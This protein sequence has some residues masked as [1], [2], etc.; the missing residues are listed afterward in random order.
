MHEINHQLDWEQPIVRVYGRKYPV[1]RMSCFL[2]DK[3]I[4]YKYSGYEHRG[5]GWPNWF[6][7]LLDKVNK[8]CEAEFN[9]CLLNLYR[10]GNDSMGWH[11]DNE[12]ELD[13]KQPIA[14]LSFGTTR[15]FYL[16]HKIFKYREDLI[17]GNGDLLIMSP[18]CQNSW[19]HSVP[20]RRK[21]TGS[22]IN[23]TFR[24]YKLKSVF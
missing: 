13:S 4:T 5:Y 24:Y 3:Y 8:K 10:N 19:L 14:S 2:A 1:P 9:G 23:L 16:K 21:I 17:I 12:P 18:S 15:D 6:S 11:S 20:I 22:R 7:P